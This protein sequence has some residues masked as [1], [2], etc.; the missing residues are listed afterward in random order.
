MKGQTE[1]CN[2]AEV[3]GKHSCCFK[4]ISRN[5]DP[6]RKSDIQFNELIAIL[7]RSIPVLKYGGGSISLWGCFWLAV[8]EKLLRI[9]GTMAGAKIRQY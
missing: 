8:T 5:K 4:A 7:K 9:N 3:E 1:K 2:N 6:K